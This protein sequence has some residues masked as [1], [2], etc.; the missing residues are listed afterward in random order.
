[1]LL[2][3]ELYFNSFLLEWY[4]NYYQYHVVNRRRF[5]INMLIKYDLLASIRDDLITLYGQAILLFF[6]YI[7]ILFALKVLYIAYIV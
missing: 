7:Y 2:T 5:K 6:F 3:K 4:F 1:M